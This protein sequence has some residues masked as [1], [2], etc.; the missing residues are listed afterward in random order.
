L[1]H[2]KSK[3]ISNWNSKVEPTYGS[4][5]FQLSHGA[6]DAPFLVDRQ[7]VTSLP[8]SA[9]VKELPLRADEE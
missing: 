8:Q 3:G 2:K 4:V 1:R 5:A 9:V 7:T 6:L